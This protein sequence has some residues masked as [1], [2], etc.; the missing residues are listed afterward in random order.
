MLADW[1]DV[2][3]LPASQPE[4]NIYCIPRVSDS[5]VDTSLNSGEKVMVLEESEMLSHENFGGTEETPEKSVTS[6]S[7]VYKSPHTTI[8]NIKGSQRSRFR[9]FWL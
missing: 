4:Q 8:Y 9:Y 2:A 7:I 3:L 1:E 5:N 6:K